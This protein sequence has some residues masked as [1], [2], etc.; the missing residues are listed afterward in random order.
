MLH[1]RNLVPELDK[2]KDDVGRESGS[3]GRTAQPLRQRQGG[4]PWKSSGAGSVAQPGWAL[5]AARRLQREQL[6]VAKRKEVKQQA[7]LAYRSR[8]TTSTTLRASATPAVR[9]VTKAAGGLNP[10]A[11]VQK[12]PKD[13]GFPLPSPSPTSQ[14][15]SEEELCEKL[16]AAREDLRLRLVRRAKMLYSGSDT[17]SDA[18]LA[19][20]APTSPMDALSP[21]AL[22]M[23]GS[24]SAISVSSSDPSPT[25][26]ARRR[27]PSDQQLLHDP[28]VLEEPLERL[29]GAADAADADFSER[30]RDREPGQESA[31]DAHLSFF[32]A[33][34]VSPT[35]SAQVLGGE[36][37]SD[38]GDDSVSE[39]QLEGPG[40]DIPVFADAFSG[41]AGHVRSSGSLPD[42]LAADTAD[43]SACYVAAT[44]DVVIEAGVVR[45][46][47]LAAYAV[48][49]ERV[50]EKA[51]EEEARAAETSISARAAAC[52]SLEPDF[53]LTMERHQNSDED[54]QDV[55][56]DAPDHAVEGVLSR[57]A[58]I[59]P[60]EDTLLQPGRSG[61]GSMASELEDLVVGLQQSMA[62]RSPGDLSTPTTALF[63]ELDQW[64]IQL[65]RKVERCQELLLTEEEDASQHQKA[66]AEE[67]SAACSQADGELRELELEALRADLQAR[68]AEAEQTLRRQHEFAVATSDA[69]VQS[70]RAEMR[71]WADECAE[72]TERNR[73][74][75]ELARDALAEM[76]SVSEHLEA[77]AH[78]AARQEEK[79]RSDPAE[80]LA[81]DAEGIVEE[82]RAP[83]ALGV[84]LKA[85]VLRW[86][87][88][89]IDCAKS[90]ASARTL[91]ESDVE[92]I[93]SEMGAEMEKREGDRHLFRAALGKVLGKA[94]Q[95]QVDL[96]EEL[97]AK[98]ELSAEL[99]AE[100]LRWREGCLDEESKR[101][102]AHEEA[103]AMAA[104]VTA[105]R[106][107]AAKSRAF[108]DR[109]VQRFQLLKS[110]RLFTEGG[111][112]TDK[113]RVANCSV[114]TPVA[115]RSSGA[116]QTDE[117]VVLQPPPPRPQPEPF[118]CAVARIIEGVNL[119]LLPELRL[120]PERVAR[121]AAQKAKDP[122]SKALLEKTADL[123]ERLRLCRYCDDVAGEGEEVAK[124]S[125][126]RHALERAAELAR[127]LRVNQQVPEER[128][129]LER[130]AELARVLKAD[131]EVPEERQTLERAAAL[132]RTFQT[133]Q[134]VTLDF[135][136]PCE[137]IHRRRRSELPREDLHH[138]CSHAPSV[139][140]RE[141]REDIDRSGDGGSSR[142]EDAIPED[143]AA[144][145]AR[146][147][148]RP[149]TRST[150]PPHGPAD[151]FDTTLYIR[152]DTARSRCVTVD[153]GCED[154]VLR[155]EEEEEEEFELLSQDAPSNW[156]SVPTPEVPEELQVLERAAELARTLRAMQE[157]RAEAGA[158]VSVG[159]A[160]AEAREEYRKLA[161]GET[162]RLSVSKDK[163]KLL[164][165]RHRVLRRKWADSQ[166][167]AGA[168]ESDSG[169]RLRGEA[170]EVWTELRAADKLHRAEAQAVQRSLDIAKDELT[171]ATKQAHA[172]AERQEA[173]VDFDE[174]LEGAVVSYAL[175]E[176]FERSA[177]LLQRPCDA[178][179]A[180]ANEQVA[181]SLLAEV[182]V[183]SL[184]ARDA[185]A[186]E[187]EALPT[188]EEAVETTSAAAGPAPGP[189]AVE[190]EE[191]T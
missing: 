186:P 113:A 19:T 16:T 120:A 174:E 123:L 41:C 166:T 119:R 99:R 59:Q 102:E 121:R 178:G 54:V 46:L 115:A 65:L 66:A 187:E 190:D 49:I 96:R 136:E 9:H 37:R 12:L 31:A 48:A 35:S 98:D 142:E 153:L 32:M 24:I 118:D 103:A 25:G 94:E 67:S 63:V 149:L 175:D 155:E 15:P 3:G 177:E 162:A 109:L 191:V 132:A 22:C 14:M 82:G 101:K 86:R 83:D 47:L 87:Q 106:I 126:E 125:E 58:S 147:L 114:Q 26:S 164:Q 78:M 42:V 57:D 36:A 167:S 11:D 71:Q 154:E 150:L 128:Q 181:A 138:R 188:T 43:A 4:V 64:R 34:D 160:V 107:S 130:A 143:A 158:S 127:T 52:D 152:M 156:T 62:W 93:R 182:L 50:H 72:L 179:S 129:A 105:L 134:E 74:G 170:K 111:M 1:P 53:G 141:D 29:L 28:E 112:Q 131:Q 75:Q 51:E 38:S 33:P 81:E 73:A 116:A 61:A 18:S 176:V 13:A 80:P 30:S 169:A 10:A 144:A 95:V 6:E 2:L 76:R 108:T 56:D 84:A 124:V 20:P 171:A 185:A 88:A 85:E 7:L 163:I 68:Q 91:Y 8:K 148:R 110:G 172:D 90:A 5:A 92:T 139:S 40:V 184:Q 161:E 44:P 146:E 135:E 69:E 104:E 17:T 165:Q 55:E 60:S 173:P 27:L 97:A 159:E 70:L 183:T 21:P 145:L 117:V 77:Q 45:K 133:N 79:D 168:E 140:L 189:A 23:S 100:L 89:Y 151:G 122:R 157:A 180:S 39:V 137:D